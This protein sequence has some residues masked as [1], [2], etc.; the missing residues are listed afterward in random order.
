MC[1]NFIDLNAVSLKD[2][3]PLMKIDL[4]VQGAAGYQLL[5]FMDAYSRYNQ[6]LM[7]KEEEKTTF[8]TN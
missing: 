6:N 7:A 8:V 2:N 4:L 1:I 3:L 5:S